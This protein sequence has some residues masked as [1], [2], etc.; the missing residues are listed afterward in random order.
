MQSEDNTVCKEVPKKL[1]ILFN[2][3]MRNLEKI[4]VRG[5]LSNDKLSLHSG[6]IYQIC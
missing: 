1:I 6:Q 2:T 3:I 4:R 5:D